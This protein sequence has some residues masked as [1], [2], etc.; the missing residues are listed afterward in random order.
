MAKNLPVCI[1]T[2]HSNFNIS[3]ID[4]RSNSRTSFENSCIPWFNHF[5]IA[6]PCFAVTEHVIQ[7]GLNEKPS[8]NNLHLGW[9]FLFLLLAHKGRAEQQTHSWERKTDIIWILQEY[10]SSFERI[11]P[12]LSFIDYLL[13]SSL[14][15]PVLSY[16]CRLSKATTSK[17][18]IHFHSRLDQIQ[19]TE[20]DN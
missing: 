6:F 16:S 20:S 10:F 14:L 2:K 17:T 8:K 3:F 19:N 15:F 5:L 9:P 11:D 18:Q 7:K 12:T 4:K 13:Y 1:H